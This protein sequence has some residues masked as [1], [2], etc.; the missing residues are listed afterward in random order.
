MSVSF[1]PNVCFK[2]AN[3]NNVTTTNLLEHFKNNCEN[4][5]TFTAT[6]DKISINKD[7]IAD[8]KYNP[9]KAAFGTIIEGFVNGKSSFFKVVSNNE[10]ENWIEGQI[11]NRYVIMHG[12]DK[13][14]DG[15]YE[16]TD[17]NLTVDYNKPSKLS[18]FY[19]QKLRGRIF[20]PDYFTVK[21]SIGDK[22]VDITL[23]NAKIPA[24]PQIRDLLTLILEDN[25]FKAQTVNG[26]IKSL[27]FSQTAIKDIKKKSEKRDKLINNDIKPIF[28]QGISSATGLIVGS[29]VSA[30][31][32]KFGLRK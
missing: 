12:K 6:N 27:K 8:L 20:M 31:L 4:S 29:V 26:E 10:E 18:S 32:L 5:Q 24:D 21:G 7:F 23:P 13:N 17:F 15:K 25:G 3:P 14:Y 2:A 19:N 30:L 1:S 22:E 11:N 28:M 9:E 16:N